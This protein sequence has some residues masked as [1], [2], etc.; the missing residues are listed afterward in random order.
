MKFVTMWLNAFPPKDRI[1]QTLSPRAIMHGTTLDVSKHCTI[2]FGSYCQ[3]HEDPNHFNNMIE[4]T[5]GA[6]CLGP[7]GNLQ[8]GYRFL[9]LNTGRCINRKQHT[10]LPMQADVIQQVKDMVKQQL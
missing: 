2:P 3:V 6:I 9:N 8:G 7:I 4:Q 5:T 1:L 10:S